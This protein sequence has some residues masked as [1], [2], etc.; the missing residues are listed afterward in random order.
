[1]YLPVHTAT[2]LPAAVHDPTK[3]LVAANTSLPLLQ[4]TYWC[5]AWRPGSPAPLASN[6]ILV[7][8][9]GHEV[10]LLHLHGR[11]QSPP[12]TAHSLE[13]RL[14]EA[15]SSLDGFDYFPIDVVSLQEDKTESEGVVNARVQVHLPAASDAFTALLNMLRKGRGVERVL[16]EAGFPAPS[17]ASLPTRCRS[18]N[19][20]LP[21]GNTVSWPFTTAGRVQPR[22]HRCEAAGDRLL[23]GRCRWNYTHGA[24]IHFDARRCQRFDFCPRGYKGLAGNFCVLLTTA[25]TWGDGLEAA[26]SS[27]NSMSLLDAS[28][29][30]EAGRMKAPSLYEEARRWLEGQEGGSVLWLP[31]RRIT[32]F[33]PLTFLGPVPSEFP[34]T[35]HDGAH[36]FNVSWAAGQPAATHDC[37]ALDTKASLLLTLPCNSTLPFL[38]VLDVS[39]L[40]AVPTQDWRDEAPNL[41]STHPLCPEGVV[42]GYPGGEDACFR[43]VRNDTR[44]TWAQAANLCASQDAHL[45]DPSRGFLDWPLRQLLNIHNIPSVWITVPQE[46]AQSGIFLNWRA[47][48]NISLPYAAL[49]PQGWVREDG[50]V[51]KAHVMCQW[52]I[53]EPKV[54]LH[55]FEDGG[56]VCVEVH[57]RDT[58][59]MGSVF[60]YVNGRGVPVSGQDSVMEVESTTQ[61]YYQCRVW[62]GSPLH[63]VTSNTFLYTRHATNTFSATLSRQSQYTPG[64]DDATFSSAVLTVQH[65]CMESFLEGFRQGLGDRPGVE[66]LTDN[67]YFTPDDTQ[68]NHT[69]INFHIEIDESEA[70]YNLLMSEAAEGLAAAKERLSDTPCRAVSIRSSSGCPSEVERD[71]NETTLTWPATRGVVVVLPTEL[72]VTEEGDP[73]TRECLGDFTRGYHWGDRSGV[74]TDEPHNV[75]RQ[76]WEI[77][78][79]NSPS[80]LASLAAL[81]A[82]GHNLTSADVH[83]VA[84]KMQSIS[85]ESPVTYPDLEFLV[86][87]LNNVMEAEEGVF[88]EVQRVLNTSSILMDAFEN[89][90]LSVKLPDVDQPVRGDRRLVSVERVDA[91]PN[92]T[93]IGYQTWRKDTDQKDEEDGD[94]VQ[95]EEAVVRKERKIN[96][97][98][99][100]V[101]LILPNDLTRRV[102][103]EAGTVEGRGW[104]P[105]GR[106]QLTFAVFRNP[107]LFQDN[108]TFPNHTVDGHIIQASYGGHSV[109]RLGQPVKIYFKIGH[110]GSE[111][112]CVFWDFQ[113]NSGHGGWSTAGCWSGGRHGEHQLCL[114]NHL[115]S[116]ARLVTF[117]GGGV[118]GVHAVVL[119]IIS[120]TGCVLSIGS[121]LLVL[122]TF[123][124]FQK[125]RRRLSN[126][127]LASLST[128]ILGSLV[129]FLAGI[130]Q[131]LVP[132]LCRAVAVA[133]HYFILAS[134]GW[135]LVE[136]V[137]QYHKFVKVF[138]TYI[139]RF[140]WKASVCAW[141]APLLPIIA[142]LVYDS[143]LYDSDQ[144]SDDKICW[145]SSTTFKF[146]FLPPLVAI[147]GINLVLFVLIVYK[148]TCGRVRITST[149]SERQIRLTQLRM[150]ISVFF[151]LGFTWIFGLLAFWRPSLVFSYLFCISN[152]LQG[153]AI[154]F[155]HV[156][157]VRDARRLWMDFLSVITRSSSSSE[158]RSLS[159]PTP[160]YSGQPS[161]PLDSN[162]VSYNQH[163]EGEVSLNPHGPEWDTARGSV[164]SSRTVS[165][166]IHS[167]SSTP[168]ML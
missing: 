10:L 98:R 155:F 74:C 154:F 38:S 144:S 112:K 9:Q 165:T 44:F 110:K 99:S 145:M 58:P 122:F 107:K 156:F 7:T 60:C 56:T 142:V 100:Q 84:Q 59:T 141:G 117:D 75:T 66:V 62:A 90:T 82:Q 149:L 81:T 157:Q 73:V 34:I 24:N 109:T 139:P 6:K 103:S 133:L 76:L 160:Q 83:F 50:N 16:E 150:A 158:P 125:W 45:P 14:R 131:T 113:E 39:G 106:V 101:T 46:A 147:M 68:A 143:T 2:L 128:A 102:A 89:I 20:M 167:R 33:G 129:V 91:T 79:Y 159:V 69:L 115:T 127:I 57:R 25:N 29:L 121:L 93:I 71:F 161:R 8:V 63:A 51:T 41:L 55:V 5:E 67:L 78:Q 111:S 85:H 148:A 114:C 88:G 95:E 18:T 28:R 140:M 54:T 26:H 123:F 136:A 13:A 146:A 49:T 64:Y 135:M 168:P 86:E 52:R 61:G 47:D 94:E 138:S 1:M 43:V 22:H 11:R 118:E 130:Q 32:P 15:F 126:K 104:A 163:G 30:H 23:T 166:I 4:G 96:W 17:R 53:Q 12:L 31:A 27:V 162:S 137:H 153:C 48:A 19:T 77:N 152:T 119:D 3:S 134:F 164:R 35:L 116:F 36:N 42:S 92:S 72:C 70:S 21:G 132:E 40:L 124:L 120:T 87:T 97:R 105:G 80:D 65:P 151:L 37:L 108:K